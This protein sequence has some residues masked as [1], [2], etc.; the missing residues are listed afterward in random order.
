MNSTMDVNRLVARLTPVICPRRLTP[1]A[2]AIEVV[3]EYMQGSAADDLHFTKD[4]YPVVSAR[5]GKPQTSIER[6]IF[7]AVEDCWMHGDNPY[8]NE[9]IGRRLPVKPKPSELIR[10][11]AFYLTYGFP[12][13]AAKEDRSMPLPF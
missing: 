4:V 10:Y 5:L 3:C 6:S 2:C 12:Y 11:C 7:R 8:M 9:I 13:H 1:L